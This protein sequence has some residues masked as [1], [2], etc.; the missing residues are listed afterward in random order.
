MAVYQYTCAVISCT[1]FGSGDERLLEAIYK[2]MDDANRGYVSFSQFA[3]TLST[4]YRWV[5]T[6]L[7]LRISTSLFLDVAVIG[8]L[9]RA[10]RGLQC[11]GLSPV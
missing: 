2:A 10:A 9:C 11:L 1:A 6:D 3:L 8:Q 4:I 5:R 7:T